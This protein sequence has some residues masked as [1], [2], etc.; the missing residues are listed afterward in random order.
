MPKLC[1]LERQLA[2][3]KRAAAVL[4]W[5]PDTVTKLKA[6]NRWSETLKDVHLEAPDYAVG[7]Q[8]VSITDR[9]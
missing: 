6:E 3:A 9:R 4:D 8:A 2:D 1:S 5:R 7:Q